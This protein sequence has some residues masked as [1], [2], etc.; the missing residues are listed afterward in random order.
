MAFK[1][2]GHL[3]D[4]LK[5]HNN[6]RPYTCTVCDAKFARSS[7]LK[8]HSH[9][10]TGLKPHKC[11]YLSCGRKFSERGNMKT[12]MKIHYRKPEVIIFYIILYNFFLEQCRYQ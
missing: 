4:H 3:K 9:T 11:P 8:I 5:I 2:H 12:H 1:A 6:E 10:H 7:T